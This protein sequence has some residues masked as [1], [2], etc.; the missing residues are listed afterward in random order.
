[1]GTLSGALQGWSQ[2][3][4]VLLSRISALSLWESYVANYLLCLSHI[5]NRS[6]NLFIFLREII[7]YYDWSQ[8]QL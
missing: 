6:F 7:L 1:M 8:A 5:S 2:I 4:S 3:L